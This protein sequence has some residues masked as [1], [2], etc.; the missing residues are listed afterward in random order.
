MEKTYRNYRIRAF[1]L[2]WFVYGGYYLGRKSFSVTKGTIGEQFHLSNLSLGYIDTAYLSMYAIGQ[3]IAGALGDR[4]SP[5]VIIGTGMILSTIM[6]CL[7]GISHGIIFFFVFNAMNG[8]AQ[9]TGW[10]A[11]V[12]SMTEWFSMRERGTIMGFWCTNYQIGGALAGMLATA[13]LTGL[14]WHGFVIIPA[15]GWHAAFIVPAL[16]LFVIAI[17]FIIF[18][19]YK[20]EDVGLRPIQDHHDKEDGKKVLSKEEKALAEPEMSAREIYLK[21]LRTKTVWIM[22][23]SYF[24]MKF[25][26]YAFMF[27]L[28]LYLYKAIHMSKSDAGIQANIAEMV[29]FLG[30]IFAGVV[31]DKLMGSRRG[32]IS[33]LMFFGLAI[34]CGVQHFFTAG[35]STWNLVGLCL[36]FFMISGPDTVMT[37]AGAMDF[38]SKRGAAT[39]AGII[40]GF[41]SV[42]AVVQSLV[43]GKISDVYGWD[44][45]FYL[46]IALAVIGGLLMTSRWYAMPETVA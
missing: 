3:F 14:A 5:K 45:F 30:A 37:G 25:V 43:L 1:V 44:F 46:F 10:S 12:K 8:L 42:G 7:F 18:H 21:V 38:G 17:I 28:P 4:Y 24:C 36:I 34:M 16:M 9:A 32:P 23:L 13:I 31:S 29:G 15:M 20:P 11:S 26:R 6:C 27:W 41:G 40:N 22:A 39:A 19:K 33:A 2:L 35:G